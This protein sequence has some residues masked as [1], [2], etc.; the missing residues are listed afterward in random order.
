MKSLPL[1]TA[2][3]ALAIAACESLNSPI[4][5]SDFN[6]LLPPGGGTTLAGNPVGFRPGDHVRAAVDNTAFFKQLPKGDADADKTLIRDTHMKVIRVA[7]SYLQVELDQS[8]EVGYVPSVMV[9]NPSAQPATLPP[10][11]GEYQVYP[12]LPGT[13]TP[14]PA[15]E[16]PVV[17]PPEGAIP[18]V[19]DPET[20]AVPPG[21]PA[22]PVEPKAE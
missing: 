12:P 7:G 10:S 19:I 21:A 9:E 2:A 4:S 15:V 6:P 20:P 11:P 13:G 1:L 8:G 14:L 5:S 3:A 16:P 18:T 17:T 22:P